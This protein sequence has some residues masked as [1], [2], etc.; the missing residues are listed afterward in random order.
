MATRT[1]RQLGGHEAMVYENALG[2][3][4]LTP[5]VYGPRARILCDHDIGDPC[6]HYLTAADARDAAADLVKVAEQVEQA[7]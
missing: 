7:T 2:T 3:M 5:T 4:M 1:I 6:S